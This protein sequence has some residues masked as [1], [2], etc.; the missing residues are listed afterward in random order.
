MADLKV[1]QLTDLGATPDP[2]D[3]FMIVDVSDTSMSA[4]GTNK[5]CLASRMGRSDG[6]IIYSQDNKA[7]TLPASGTAALRAAANVF[8][9]AQ[10]IT[11]PTSAADVPTTLSLVSFDNDIYCGPILFVG[12]NTNATTPAAGAIGFNDRL[13]TISYV[14]TD[15]AN[16][17][18]IGASRPKGGSDTT[19]SVVGDQT[20]ALAAKDIIPGASTI[21]EIWVRIQAGADAVRRFSYKSGAYNGQEFEGVV[22]DY[23]PE[24]GKDRDD[25]FP[26]GKALN[27]INIVGDLLRA[28]ADLSAR[29]AVLEAA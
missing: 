18:R 3:Y 2:A 22:V 16:L 29:V 13:G 19:G 8:T 7:L 23:A 14:W 15:D 5:K 20:S 12:R 26:N 9:A 17:L 21:A 25:E 6:A 27:E 1:T 28:V 11:L 10:S 4:S 24:Y